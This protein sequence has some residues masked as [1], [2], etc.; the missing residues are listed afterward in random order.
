MLSFLAIIEEDNPV[1]YQLDGMPAGVDL[2]DLAVV[3]VVLGAVGQAA[4]VPADTFKLYSL[5]E[6]DLCRIGQPAIF[7]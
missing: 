5:R 2:E 7:E 3:S 6:K 4:A 1:V